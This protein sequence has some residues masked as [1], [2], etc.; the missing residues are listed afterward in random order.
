[1]DGLFNGGNVKGC[2]D[3]LK[4]SSFTEL[5]HSCPI[6]RETNKL[7]SGRQ[8]RL[9]FTLHHKYPDPCRVRQKVG[10]LLQQRVFKN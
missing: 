6:V 7:W 2:L 4:A 9:I 1:M 8:S 5:S 3:F 10:Y